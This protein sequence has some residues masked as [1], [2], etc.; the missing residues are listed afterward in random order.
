MN[1]TLRR[2]LTRAILLAM[3]VNAGVAL[4]SWTPGYN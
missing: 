3:L 2:F 1:G 4:P